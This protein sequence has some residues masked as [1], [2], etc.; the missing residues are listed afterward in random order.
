ML[1]ECIDQIGDSKLHPPTKR[2]YLGSHGSRKD[3]Y[4]HNNEY[5]LYDSEILKDLNMKGQGPLWFPHDVRQENFM[6]M[7]PAVKKDKWKSVTGYHFH[8]FFESGEE[9]RFKYA[10]YGHPVKNALAQPRLRGVH[11]DLDMAVRCALGKHTKK[12]EISFE[13]IP[14]T[15][16]P[17]YYLNEET[18]QARHRVWQDIVRRDEGK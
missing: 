8:N 1:G 10:T 9:I 4:G 16:R 14:S 18:R 12:A 3:S 13:S 6:G 2:V 7:L 11:K 15:S 5:S 17:I